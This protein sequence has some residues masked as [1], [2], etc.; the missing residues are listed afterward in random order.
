M[1]SARI[2]LVVLGVLL[3]G[4]FGMLGL[5]ATTADVTVNATIARGVSIA[6]DNSTIDVSFGGNDAVPFTAYAFPARSDRNHVTQTARHNGHGAGEGWQITVKSTGAFTNGG[7]GTL[8][9]DQLMYKILDNGIDDSADGFTSMTNTDIKIAD[10][11][12]T[13]CDWSGGDV[14]VYFLVNLTGNE[15]AGTYNCPIQFTIAVTP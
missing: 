15:E 13:G 5:A 10:E 9:V 7:A 4:A 2:L 3:V 14:P 8:T 11:A 12:T 6:V 1:K